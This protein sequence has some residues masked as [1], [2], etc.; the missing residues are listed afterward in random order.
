MKRYTSILIIS[1]CL[2]FLAG[3]CK[4]DF[5]E[6]IDKSK[7]LRE[8]Y[9][10]DLVTTEHYMNGV[11]IDIAS[12]FAGV[13]N[14]PLPELVADNIKPTANLVTG[15]SP[16]VYRWNV[17]K[18][19]DLGTGPW[20]ENYQIIRSCNY[21]IEKSDEFKDQDIDKANNLK[22]QALTIR[23]WMHFVLVNMFAQS[24]NFTNDASHPGVPYIRSSDVEENI[25]RVS[26][27]EVYNAIGDDLNKAMELLPANVTSRQFVNRFCTSALLA[28]VNL[29]KE[30]YLQA[31]NFSV[32]ILNE[33][34][35]MTANYPTKLYTSVETEALFQLPPGN[36]QSADY[37]I[38]FLGQY[39]ANK[40][41][42]RFLATNDLV[43]LYRSY[44]ADKRNAW[45]RDS[46][47]GKVVFK[48]P[49][50]VTGTHAT[51]ESDY[52][53]TLLRS[54]EMVLTAA[55][56]YSK[57]NMDDSARYFV[58][59]IRSRAGIPAITTSITGVALLDS[60]RL[61]RRKEMAFDGIRM[62][63]LQRWHLSVDR[64]DALAS[65]FKLLQYP[66]EKAIFPIPTPDVD[67]A[68]VTQNPGY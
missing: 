9:V 4:K 34:P 61:E 39:Y 42:L 24:Y 52:Y 19:F 2:S 38:S 17:T 49:K 18:E 66:N 59:Q 51:A 60:I 13:N 33:V 6:V 15:I 43:S 62:F 26:V 53:Q 56:A 22:G 37:N 16:T 5:L 67:V 21:V 64:Q 47:I 50:A 29:F 30:N 11:Y 36:S 10:V 20:G 58:N 7:L 63:D 68:G 35:L 1:F 65:T 32:Q 14:L 28:R 25:R 23:A 54:T 48:F 45:V 27:A 12:K 44:P 3:A 31:K 8:G 46:S 55:E 57:L 40:T 41:S